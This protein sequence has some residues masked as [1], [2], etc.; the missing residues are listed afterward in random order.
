VVF[1]LH[2][3]GV[4]LPINLI[5]IMN[6][7]LNTSRGPRA[8]AENSG[9]PRDRKKTAILLLVTA[10]LGAAFV[11]MQAFEWTKL[12]RKASVPGAIRGARRNLAP[13]SS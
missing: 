4:Y 6:F 2:L 9:Y 10:L 3:G 13:P 1:A 7:V 8:R 5:A 11:G 12:I